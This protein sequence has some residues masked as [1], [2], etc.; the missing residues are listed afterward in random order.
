M[1]FIRTVSQQLCILITRMLQPQ[2]YNNSISVI[3]TEESRQIDF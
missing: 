3:S 1:M 2:M